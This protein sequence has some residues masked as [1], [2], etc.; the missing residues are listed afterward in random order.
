M[1]HFSFVNLDQTKK[2]LMTQG[3]QRRMV[4]VVNFFEIFF[5]PL[6]LLYLT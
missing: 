1:W 5:F 3:V 6:L 4:L 2:I